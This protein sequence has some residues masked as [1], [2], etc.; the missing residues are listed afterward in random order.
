MRTLRQTMI[1]L[2]SC[3]VILG[4]VGRS[5][6]TAN[7]KLPVK[8]YLMAGQSNLEGHASVKWLRD[9]RPKLMTPRDDVWCVAAQK[10]PGPMRPGYGV[11]AGNFGL[12]LMMGHVL[13]DAVAN[14][15][16][17]FKTGR[18][19]TTLYKQWRP[20]STVKRAGGEVG[21]LY[22]RMIRRF[23][24]LL[25]NAEDI[26]P[27]YKGQGIEVA[28]FVWFQGENDSLAM[29]EDGVGYWKSYEAN[30][31]DLI[32]DVRREVGVPDLPVLI[33]QIN[34]GLWDGIDKSTGK[35][36]KGGPTIRAAQKKVAETDPHGT[37]IKTSDLDTGY[38]YDPPSHLEIG[39]RAGK[40]LVPFIKKTVPQDRAVIA[41]ARQKFFS[42][43][44]KPGKPD[45][46]SLNKGLLGY[47]QFEEGAGVKTADASGHKLEGILEGDP[48]WT[49]GRLGKAVRLTGKQCIKIR[50]FTEP[51]VDVVLRGRPQPRIA[52]LSVAFWLRTNRWGASYVGKATPQRKPVRYAG[53]WFFS[54]RVARGWAVD[55]HDNG[56]FPFVTAMF[57]NG[58]NGMYPFDEPPERCV[59]GDGVEW[60]HVVMI[61]D[62]ARKTFEMYTDGVVADKTRGSNPRAL[63]GIGD[64]NHIVPART[65]LQIGGHIETPGHFQVFDELAIWDRPLT[66]EEAKAL[67]NNGYGAAIK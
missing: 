51:T 32:A 28:G 24:N 37:W 54:P 46:S 63:K 21:P 13:G 9:N 7:D 59:A 34:D 39:V 8:V 53:N 42:Q 18:G 66:A 36:T 49:R 6:A 15:V 67:Y 35:A 62:G 29:T 60:H 57:D 26:L 12:E 65:Q 20:P 61:Y 19:G 58:P 4:T 31:K 41:A 43:F 38:H 33:V 48:A 17:L 56:G 44:P 10:A 2:A 14:R 11:R 55:C 22:T 64:E 25:D 27:W 47:W 50:K 45:T 1:L 23:H 52:N 30:L 5:E 16:V 40:A 3:G